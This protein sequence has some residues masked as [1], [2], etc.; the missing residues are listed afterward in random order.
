MR[1]NL[2]GAGDG[3]APG[4]SARFDPVFDAL[5]GV[6]VLRGACGF[7]GGGDGGGVEVLGGVC[8]FDGGGGG[9]GG[10]GGGAGPLGG[11]IEYHFSTF[12]LRTV[13]F[14]DSK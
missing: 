5:L 10:D 9:G 4:G 12:F 11:P 6:E 3:A 13:F 1:C 2:F 14:S 8:G 7:D